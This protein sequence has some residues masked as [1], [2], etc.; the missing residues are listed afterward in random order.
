MSLKTV[1]ILLILFG[2]F[3]QQISGRF[4]IPEWIAIRSKT[5]FKWDH[6]PLDAIYFLQKSIINFCFIFYQDSSK[7]KKGP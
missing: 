4:M 7:Y 3:F 5:A 6:V 2:N 1:Q